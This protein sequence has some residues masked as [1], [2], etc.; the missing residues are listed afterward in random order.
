MKFGLAV[1]II[2][3]AAG[4]FLL[5]MGANVAAPDTE[6]LVSIVP[7]ASAESS[8]IERRIAAAPAGGETART[9]ERARIRRVAIP[10]PLPTK[11]RAASMPAT[12]RRHTLAPAPDTANA[13]DAP[14]GMKSEAEPAPSA[15]AETGTGRAAREPAD[16][17]DADGDAGEAIPVA[18]QN[19]KYAKYLS[20]VRELVDRNW[21]DV[22]GRKTDG[23]VVIEFTIAKSGALERAVIRRASGSLN[24]DQAALSAVQKTEPFPRIPDTV[25]RRQSLRL[26]MLFLYH[27]TE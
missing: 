4:G 13:T 14:G 11:T 1:S 18:S 8:G 20:I 2:L 7:E 22:L 17:S 24:L 21:T 19:P 6:M 9:E 10:A 25:R 23:T 16:Q 15:A 12:K 27:T 5:V 3:H 26:T